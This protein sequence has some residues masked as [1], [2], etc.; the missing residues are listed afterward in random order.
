VLKL[1]PECTVVIH[2]RSHPL[3]YIFLRKFSKINFLNALESAF[4]F[5]FTPISHRQARRIKNRKNFCLCFFLFF[6]TYKNP[7][8]FI[9][10]KNFLSF[11]ESKT[12]EKSFLFF[13]HP[14][15]LFVFMLFV[16]SARNKRGKKEFRCAGRM[17]KNG[18]LRKEKFVTDMYHY[19]AYS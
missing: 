12:K 2:Q 3:H 4:S 16:M 14:V 8:K 7:L 17:M 10:R 11:S 9:S 15:L 13:F 6:V 5:F 19:F 1:L 18:S